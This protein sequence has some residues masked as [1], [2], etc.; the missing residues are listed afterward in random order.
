MNGVAADSP[1]IC[2]C[3]MS[4][5]SMRYSAQVMLAASGGQERRVGSGGRNGATVYDK[6]GAI[7][8]PGAVRG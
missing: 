8:R 1:W 5:P 7:D 2:G 3:L 4:P 6:L